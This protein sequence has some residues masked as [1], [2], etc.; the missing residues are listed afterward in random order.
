MNEAREVEEREKRQQEERVSRG[1]VTRHTI[2]T[3]SIELQK[4]LFQKCSRD[5]LNMGAFNIIFRTT[6][7]RSAAAEVLHRSKVV[8]KT[9]NHVKAKTG[10]NS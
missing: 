6:R 2:L 5:L 10:D 1:R 4:Y 9:I 7:I 3:V 8:S